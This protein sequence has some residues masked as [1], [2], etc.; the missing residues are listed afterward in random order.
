MDDGFHDVGPSAL[1]IVVGTM[2]RRFFAVR[3][4]VV[5]ASIIVFSAKYYTVVCFPVSYVNSY[6]SSLPVRSQ[7][8]KPFQ[9]NPT[10][11]VLVGR[12]CSSKETLDSCP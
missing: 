4:D 10:L 6:R 1:L 11:R 8:L 3:Y 12:L 5:E 7:S 9:P 2:F